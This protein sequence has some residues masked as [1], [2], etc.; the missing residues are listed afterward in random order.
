[1]SR[2]HACCPKKPMHSMWTNTTA[3]AIATAIDDSCMWQCKSGFTERKGGCCRSKPKQ[4][5]WTL[6]SSCEWRCT[7]GLRAVGDQCVD[8]VV[9]EV[10]ADWDV[11]ES[12]RIVDRLVEDQ[13]E[14]LLQS[15]MRESSD[16]VKQ[17]LTHTYNSMP[18]TNIV[19]H[20]LTHTLHAHTL[21]RSNI[22]SHT[23]FRK[24]LWR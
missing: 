19:M 1:M 7:K 15:A 22:H 24:H 23:F 10:L 4:A 21:S 6:H 8:D 9:A 14:E 12:H 20:S 2:P 13:L 18:H 5:R 3:T 17:P 16:K 11:A